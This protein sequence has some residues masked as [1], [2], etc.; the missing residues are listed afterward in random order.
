[1]KTLFVLLAATI[2]II[3]APIFAPYDP[4]RTTDQPLMP[5]G[6][7]HWLGTDQL[8][9]D[10]FSRL[11]V[12]GQRSLLIAA[13]STL[14]AVIG[15]GLLGILSASRLS[16]LNV[17]LGASIDALLAFP[18]LLLSLLLLALFGS[19][20]VQIAGAVGIALIAQYARITR[21]AVIG[22]RASG[23]VDAAR[24]MGARSARIMVYHI[25]PNIAVLLLGYAGVIFSYSLFNSAALSFLGF[26][27]SPGV[28]DWGVMLYEG[29]QVLR[30]A[31]W[32]SL[33]PGISISLLIY[34]IN[35]VTDQLVN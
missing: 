9:R 7:A 22:A 32:M 6:T 33:A 29:R 31:P 3:T 8:G 30:V 15:G 17:L 27:D 10:V 35:Q 20:W 26:G 13:L 5:P 4:M 11:L 1:M 21:T 28:P 18:A 34:L 23:Y 19:G 24:A 25:L 16:W 14:I 2:A 12:G